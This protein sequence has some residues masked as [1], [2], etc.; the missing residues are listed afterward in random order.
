VTD[1]SRGIAVSGIAFHTFILKI[2]FFSFKYAGKYPVVRS[3]SA[4]NDSR[5][6]IP[7]SR[8]YA[9]GVTILEILD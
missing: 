2:V 9:L 1:V 7:D 5:F 4:C 6:Q 3:Q 8:E